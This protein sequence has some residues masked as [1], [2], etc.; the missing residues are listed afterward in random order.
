[1][2]ELKILNQVKKRREKQF[3]HLFSINHI[4]LSESW[5][6]WG[7]MAES[8][9]VCTGCQLSPQHTHHLKPQPGPGQGFRLLKG[10]LFIIVTDAIQYK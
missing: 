2:V 8:I 6:S 1:M 3:I 7:V 4:F 10:K 9:T 5:G